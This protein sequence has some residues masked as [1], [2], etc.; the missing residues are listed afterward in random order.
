MHTGLRTN[1]HNFWLGKLTSITNPA[2][3][4]N[5]VVLHDRAVETVALIVGWLAVDDVVSMCSI[6][7]VTNLE[8]PVYKEVVRR[9]VLGRSAELAQYASPR[10]NV[11]SLNKA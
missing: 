7:A 5:R 2:W 3:V 4:D 6:N 11:K 8:G 9:V 10:E 1:I